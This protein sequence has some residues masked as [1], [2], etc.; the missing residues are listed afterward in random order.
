[1]KSFV[2]TSR[3]SPSSPS[4]PYVL[5]RQYDGCMH[6]LHHAQ[7]IVCFM[8]CPQEPL[9]LIITILHVA[10]HLV[11]LRLAVPLPTCL[12]SKLTFTT[13]G[14]APKATHRIIFQFV[15]IIFIQ[16]YQWLLSPR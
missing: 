3:L 12:L 6:V 16:T 1:M 8:T 13:I 2:F 7:A 11:S 5:E 4:R 15:A 14:M 9:V 10:R